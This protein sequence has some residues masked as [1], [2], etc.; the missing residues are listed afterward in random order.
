MSQVRGTLARFLTKH[1]RL[2]IDET[3]G[4]D[5]DFALDRLDGIDDNSNG[6][7]GKLFE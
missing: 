2:W 4:I 6:S 5:N 3:E 7:R 1:K